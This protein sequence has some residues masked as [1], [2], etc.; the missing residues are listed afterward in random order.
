MS[1]ERE[2]RPSYDRFQKLMDRVDTASIKW[3]AE[4]ISAYRDALLES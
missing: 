2:P 4:S 1:S 3:W